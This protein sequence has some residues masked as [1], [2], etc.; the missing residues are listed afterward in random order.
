MCRE[1]KVLRI[2]KTTGVKDIKGY[3]DIQIGPI[4]I[5]GIKIIQNESE[6]FCALPSENFFSKSAG[7]SLNRAMVHIE[8]ELKSK[9]YA[10]ILKRWNELENLKFQNDERG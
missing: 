8:D 1:F 4:T 2:R 10:E 6:I 3:A 5:W 9:L 7:R